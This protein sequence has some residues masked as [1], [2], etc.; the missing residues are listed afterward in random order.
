VKN[1]NLSFFDIIALE[2]L[3]IIVMLEN[4]VCLRVVWL[5]C[6]VLCRKDKT[7]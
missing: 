3:Q 7:Q 2:L 1:A 6:K 4:I 5:R